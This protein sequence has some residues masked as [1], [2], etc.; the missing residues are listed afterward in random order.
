MM[1]QVLIYFTCTQVYSLKQGNITDPSHEGITSH[2]KAQLH[3]DIEPK[4][5]F[6]SFVPSGIRTWDLPSNPN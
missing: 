4:K 3:D 5:T 1:N 2:T 6:Q